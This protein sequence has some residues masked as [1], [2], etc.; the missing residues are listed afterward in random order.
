MDDV[1]CFDFFRLCTASMTG[2]V[3]PGEK[4]WSRQMLQAAH[5]E[6]AAWRAV[7]AL[8]ALHRRWEYSN[9]CLS[10][11]VTRRGGPNMT[12]DKTDVQVFTQQATKHYAVSLSLAKGIS[13]P[14]MLAIISV[15][16]G[17]AAHLGGKWA[18][19]Q[20]HIRAG[21][22]LLRMIQTSSS[23][24]AM[25]TGR[26]PLLPVDLE[27]A[28]QALERLDAQA[29]SL[30][31]ATSPYEY[32]RDDVEESKIILT[33]GSILPEGSD[34]QR[35][36]TSLVGPMN[37][38][39]Q[40]SLAIFRLMRQF[41][42]MSDAVTTGTL[43]PR[44]FE[45]AR[46]QM[47]EA[48][49][50]WEAE[51]GVLIETA[52]SRFRFANETAPYHK[53][54][55]DQKVLILSMK[56]YHTTLELLLL[57]HGQPPPPACVQTPAGEEGRQCLSFRPV[58][59]ATTSSLAAGPGFP[60][61]PTVPICAGATFSPPTYPSHRA[62]TAVGRR[63][64]DSTTAED[65][66]S[67][68][69]N[70]M[71]VADGYGPPGY[72]SNP[73]LSSN[74]PP[75][76]ESASVDS[77]MSDTPPSFCTGASSAPSP[78]P[79]PPTSAPLSSMPSIRAVLDDTR[80][81]PNQFTLNT[82]GN[83]PPNSTSE[84]PDHQIPTAETRWDALHSHFLQVVTLASEIAHNTDSPLPF[85]M[86]LEPGLAMPLY[87]TIK[88]CR[89]PI[90]RRRALGLLR[91]LNRQEGIWNCAIAARA[92]EELVLLEEEGIL[93]TPTPNPSSES[94]PITRTRTA[95]DKSPVHSAPEKVLIPLDFFAKTDLEDSSD[96][97]LTQ[98]REQAVQRFQRLHQEECLREGREVDP[99]IMLGRYGGQ[100]LPQ[101]YWG[102]GWPNIPE[103]KRILVQYP[104]IRMEKNQLELM[105]FLVGDSRGG[106]GKMARTVL[107]DLV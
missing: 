86:S 7:V 47:M 87:L 11:R 37:D 5:V 53:S 57:A 20:V 31:D 22:R 34:H 65:A 55:R 106:R 83:D 73:P 96:A 105:M 48:T 76:S 68:R 71:S 3:F 84:L 78:T 56:L 81:G 70:D 32:T 50:Q 13:D 54:E 93:S 82:T 28:A 69:R 97:L 64:T 45:L 43:T 61:G 39:G 12:G 91:R 6:P 92:A 9:N 17:A 79:A 10:P 77:F 36:P 95:Q 30:S 14:A 29:M 4:F 16:L 103:E 26:I 67:P 99:D 101:P 35:S 2:S 102:D 21:L 75:F 19:S 40:A 60:P 66:N 25:T 58:N 41:F 52:T 44:E 74:L 1:A 104:I 98:F 107:V 42:I 51:L 85:F 23:K 94:L 59:L 72:C 100:P 90:T 46:L 89:H 62:N 33:D 63:D 15:A 49:S 38:L 8:G 88:R 27:G 80:H 18:D 24:S